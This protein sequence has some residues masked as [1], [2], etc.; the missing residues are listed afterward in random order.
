MILDARNKL[1]AFQHDP[2]THD[3]IVKLLKDMFAN[4]V[5]L[6]RGQAGVVKKVA[7][8]EYPIGCGVNYHTAFRSIEKSNVTTMKYVQPDPIPLEFGTRLFVFKSS[9]TPALSQLFTLWV[10][11]DGQEAMGKFAWRGMPWNPKAHK[12]EISKGKS[13]ILCDAD[14]ALKFEDFE[15]E[16]QDA[17]QIPVAKKS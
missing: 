3:W 2:K 6:E 13:I 9:R 1:Q 15:A 4:G 7:S 14:C 11:T 10:A 17:L 5:V 16:Y 8:G 12:Y